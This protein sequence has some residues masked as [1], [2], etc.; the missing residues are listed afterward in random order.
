[1]KEGVA[2]SKIHYPLL[3]C[4]WKGA[5]LISCAS[6]STNDFICCILTCFLSGGHLIANSIL[7]P[8]FVENWC[9][10][11]AV[12][13]LKQSVFSYL[14][15]NSIKTD[16]ILWITNN[17]KMRHWQRLCEILSPGT[18]DKSDT[19]QI[20]PKLLSILVF[21]PLNMTLASTGSPSGGVIKTALDLKF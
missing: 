5:S 15:E 8:G 2:E 20:P 1:M 19:T 21:T 13:L 9:N 3:R 11:V 10:W 4:R 17:V 12:H 14:V 18:V 6:Y 16:R 7:I